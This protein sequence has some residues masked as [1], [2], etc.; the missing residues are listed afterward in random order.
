MMN[1]SVLVVDDEA[2]PRTV[3]QKHIPWEELSVTNVYLATDGEEGIEQ[4]R[5]FRPEII[6]SDIRMPRLNGLEMA[7]AVREFLP[8]CQLIFLSLSLCQIFSKSC[9][10]CLNL[11]LCSGRPYAHPGAVVHIIIENIGGWESGGLYLAASHVLDGIQLVVPRVH[12]LVA[13]YLGGSIAPQGVHD[14]LD[15]GQSL[16]TA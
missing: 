10:I 14:I 7:A 1:F 11:R 16:D 5:R 2:M 3:L 15:L 12:Y 9:K 8:A 4:A 13:A 6:I